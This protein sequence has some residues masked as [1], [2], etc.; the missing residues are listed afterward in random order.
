MR[1]EEMFLGA[2]E[3]TVQILKKLLQN[4]H[5][6]VVALTNWSAET[7]KRGCMLFPFFKSF[8]EVL[9]SGQEGGKPVGKKQKN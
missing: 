7:W 4:E 6:K 9:V 2:I 1:W 3:G 5:Y 8:E